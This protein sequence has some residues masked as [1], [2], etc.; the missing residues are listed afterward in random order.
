MKVV[1]SKQKFLTG[2]CASL[3][4]FFLMGEANAGP[5]SYSTRES[6]DAQRGTSPSLRG[7]KGTVDRYEQ[8]ILRV[9]KADQAFLQKWEKQQVKEMKAKAKEQER[10]K[11]V[12]LK[13]KQAEEKR[14]KKELEKA[15]KQ[16]RARQKALAKKIET[17]VGTK[18]EKEKESTPPELIDLKPKEEQQPEVLLEDQKPQP[19]RKVFS[20]W[21][22]ST[23]DRDLESNEENVTV[24]E[25][26]N[27]AVS[28]PQSDTEEEKTEQ[29]S[30]WG[31]LKKALW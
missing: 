17:D 4:L 26:D 9:A 14:K 15:E 13:E 21:G 2:L 11:K 5:W 7:V 29:R 1:I 24:S 10:L 3:V 28:E 25:P 19:K 18:K 20:L 16:A 31:H 23:T 22:K 6:T 8:R 27:G 30:L 12:A